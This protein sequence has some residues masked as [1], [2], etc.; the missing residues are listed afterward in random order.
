MG[1]GA[2]GVTKRCETAVIYDLIESCAS[3][4]HTSRHLDM[5]CD[6]A[7][8]WIA[9]RDAWLEQGF[10]EIRRALERTPMREVPATFRG[11]RWAER[12]A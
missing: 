8:E 6:E 5:T 9:W 3:G 4:R 2:G 1:R 12:H 7:D 11:P 10:A